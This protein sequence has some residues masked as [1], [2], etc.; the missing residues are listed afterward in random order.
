VRFQASNIVPCLLARFYR[1][2][3]YYYKLEL[4]RSYDAATAEAQAAAL[5]VIKTALIDPTMFDFD[6]LFKLDAVVKLKDHPL[7]SLLNV[8][9][10]GNL[11][12]LENWNK[13]NSTTLG[14]FGTC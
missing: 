4:V 7:F 12:D 14:E 2:D 9:M 10:S 3:V 8:F 13:T 1:A 11:P 5:D 6:Q